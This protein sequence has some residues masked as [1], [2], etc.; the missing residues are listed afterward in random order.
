MRKLDPTEYITK[1][2]DEKKN[3]GNTL[4]LRPGVVALNF[5][6]DVIFT[7]L[8][9]KVLRAIFEVQNFK[10]LVDH[11]FFGFISINVLN[12][13][14]T[15]YFLKQNLSFPKHSRSIP[16]CVLAVFQKRINRE[17][18]AFIS[19]R[20][21]PEIKFKV[22]RYLFNKKVFQTFFA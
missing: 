6:D 7:E 4:R 10:T 8:S 5:I 18:V 3:T 16:S 21:F 15:G 20:Q 2:V 14:K 13:P 19:L 17:T 12:D 22:I 9:Q 11:S 1:F